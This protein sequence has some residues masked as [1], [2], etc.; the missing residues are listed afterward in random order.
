MCPRFNKSSG[1]WSRCTHLRSWRVLEL[2][3]SVFPCWRSKR[4][5]QSISMYRSSTLK[6]HLFES[7]PKQGLQLHTSAHE[8]WHVFTLPDA[9]R[10]VTRSQGSPAG[11]GRCQRCQQSWPGPRR[12]EPSM[13]SLKLRQVRI[14]TQMNTSQER[15]TVNAEII[16]CIHI[17]IY[18]YII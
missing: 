2:L 14:R 7:R 6:V 4:Q 9:V 11:L 13:H 17:F 16:L 10:N 12:P 3:P 1:L 15:M 8:F 5:V 18:V